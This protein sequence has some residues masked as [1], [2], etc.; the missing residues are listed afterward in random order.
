MEEKEKVNNRMILRRWKR[1]SCEADW[2]DKKKKKN[3]GS[4]VVG[5][6]GLVAEIK[7]KAAVKNKN[8]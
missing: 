6:E 7:D 5:G 8:L 1:V 4:E 2:N 3:F